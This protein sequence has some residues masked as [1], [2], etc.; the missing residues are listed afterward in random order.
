M[1]TLFRQRKEGDL[2]SD[3]KVGKDISQQFIIHNLP[4]NCPKMIQGF[5]NINS[6]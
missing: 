4:G 5:L 2:F 3:A 6:H 1:N